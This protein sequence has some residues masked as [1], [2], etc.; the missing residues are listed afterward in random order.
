MDQVKVHLMITLKLLDSKR[1]SG[2]KAKWLMIF[3]FHGRSL[4]WVLMYWHSKS[5]FLP[6]TFNF[7]LQMNWSK[8]VL[9]V[10]IPTK[11]LL[12]IFCFIGSSVWRKLKVY[13][14]THTKQ[15]P[16]TINVYLFQNCQSNEIQK[17][18]SNTCT[19]ASKLNTSKIVTQLV[20]IRL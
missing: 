11:I 14:I 20:F 3:M 13:I 4:I 7:E 6:M 10:N 17:K 15:K 5:A 19:N 8:G 2:K 9:V 18:E 16:F 1:F 12:T